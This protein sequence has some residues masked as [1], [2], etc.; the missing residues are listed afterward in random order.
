MSHAPREEDRA[1]VSA[2]KKAAKAMTF[3]SRMRRARSEKD[4]DAAASAPTGHGTIARLSGM[5]V[6]ASGHV[7]YAD[8]DEEHGDGD[9]A[10][11]P[12]TQ[13][14]LRVRLVGFKGL[15]PAQVRRAPIPL[16]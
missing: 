1:R 4:D 12:L 8:H 7:R 2:M 15:T 5:R 14:I 6:E 10:D 13:G 3:F 9:G 16:G 11:G